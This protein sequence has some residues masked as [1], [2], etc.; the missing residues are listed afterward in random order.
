MLVRERE[1]EVAKME[2]L[3]YA[4]ALLTGIDKAQYD[5]K[6]KV[7]SDLKTTMSEVVHQDI[8]MAGYDRVKR[9]A[10]QNTVVSERALLEKLTQL[11]SSGSK[12]E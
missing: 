8:Y 2:Y 10:A 9:G 3:V 1:A 4:Q 12:G 6:M 11:G 5:R 7:L